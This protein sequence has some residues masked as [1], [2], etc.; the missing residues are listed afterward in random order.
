MHVPT[1]LINLPSILFIVIIYFSGML[2][3]K[4][5]RDDVFFELRMQQ[6]LISFYHDHLLLEILD[7][8]FNRGLPIRD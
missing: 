5:L 7:S 8:R 1:I 2:Y 6:Q 3:Q 4:I